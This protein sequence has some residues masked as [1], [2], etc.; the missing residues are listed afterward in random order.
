MITEDHLSE[1]DRVISSNGI[2]P[3]HIK[4]IPNFLSKKPVQTINFFPSNLTLKRVYK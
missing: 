1:V 2:K 4:H 3:D